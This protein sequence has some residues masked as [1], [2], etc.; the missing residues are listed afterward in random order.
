MAFHGGRGRGRGRGKPAPSGR[1][2]RSGIRT[3]GGQY[4]KFDS[5]RTREIDPESGEDEPL[6]Q[7][8][9]SESEPE[10]EEDLSN[11]EPTTVQSYSTLLASLKA[12]HDERPK[13]R[14]KISI[15][16]DVTVH[17]AAST[18]ETTGI[19]SRS[20]DE[21]DEAI[22]G[23]SDVDESGQEP[24]NDEDDSDPY[25]RHFVQQDDDIAQLV[26][27]AKQDL[28]PAA[29]RIGPSKANITE[30]A[31]GQALAQ[32]GPV[33]VDDKH[34]KQRL[35][36]SARKCLSQLKD[37]QSMLPSYLLTYT[38]I[39]YGIR[40]PSNASQLRQL[41]AL[42]AVNHILRGR[43]KILKNNGRLTQAGDD[44]VLECRDQ[45][46]TRPK[47]LILTETRQMCA[48]YAEAVVDVFD[49][50]QQENSKR[51]QEAFSAP[52]VDRDMPEDYNELFGGNNDNNFVTTIKFTRKTLK[53]YSAFYQ[54][55]IIFASPLGLQRIIESQDKRKRDHDFLSSIELVI[56]DQADAS[57][58]QNFE[59][60]ELVFKHLNLQPKELRDC[61]V[62]RVR[63]F[64]LDGS[65]QYFRQTVILSAYLTPELNKLYNSTMRNIAGKVKITKQYSGAIQAATGLGIKQT[66]VRFSPKSPA[67]DP[68]A[69]FKFFTTSVL[70]LLLRLPRPSSGGQG[71]L[72]FIPSYF[73]FLRVRNFFAT[74][75][76]TE[77]ISFG[78]INDYSEVSDQRRARSHFLSGRHNILL[79][80]ERSHHFFRLR[81]R[82]VKN[83]VMYGL[84]QNELFYREIVADFLSSS[85]AQG[86][87]GA[88]ECT[89]RTMFSKYDALKLERVVGSDRTKNM[90][91]GIGDTFDF[92]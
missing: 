64:Y 92:V 77:N 50:D 12:D 17:E 40:T 13:K 59:N 30:H 79:Y 89:A 26:R 21:L 11:D 20:G 91:S 53:F 16:E 28:W 38:D 66:F 55:D 85:L 45:G 1:V 44:E 73:D 75:T 29:K 35:R 32:K 8:V 33:N 81:L 10:S 87:T 22:D 39:L 72:I 5:Q 19:A 49:P 82:G 34:I 43:D 57:Q 78:A 48:K 2:A 58:M 68:D 47:V 27:A 51:F 9:Q 62:N 80:T 52:L 25:E 63:N 61:D 83:V 76:M 86:N 41:M 90:L 74:S 3:R 56:V 36:D 4:K 65:A 6:A 37:T 31:P 7:D 67:D 70:P 84:P 24:D 14:R 60:I 23:G 42:H 88:A 46:F 15:S 69:R 18:A 54:S 71:I